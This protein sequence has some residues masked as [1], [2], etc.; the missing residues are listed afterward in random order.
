MAFNPR[1]IM[2]RLRSFLAASARFPG[3]TG[4]GEPKGPPTSPYA[5][6]ILGDITLTEL[7]LDHASGRVNL[8]VRIYRDAFGEP[9]DETE[10]YLGQ[11]VLELVE[12]F[13][14]DFDF[15]DD[16]VRGLIALEMAARPGY[17][18]IGADPNR[19]YRVVDIT[20]PL[21]VNDIAALT[22]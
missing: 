17:Q 9:L 7:S 5:A 16:N 15:G 2:E 11:T 22:R 4:I 8:I 13:C 19:V 6:V 10:F 21:L 18:T 12:D 20:V 1:P 3:G 14:A